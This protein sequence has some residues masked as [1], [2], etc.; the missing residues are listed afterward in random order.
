MHAICS[1]QTLLLS[2]VLLRVLYSVLIVKQNFIDNRPLKSTSNVSKGVFHSIFMSTNTARVVFDVKSVKDLCN[3]REIT[4]HMIKLLV[5]VH[6]YSIYHL[7]FLPR[8]YSVLNIL[9]IYVL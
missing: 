7:H 8:D 5:H 3:M 2:V 1:Q 9:Y 4:K 6:E